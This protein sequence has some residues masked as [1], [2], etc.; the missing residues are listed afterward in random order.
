MRSPKPGRPLT[1]QACA[2]G[3][4]RRKNPKSQ[5][6]ARPSLDGPLPF[7]HALKD[8]SRNV[9]YLPRPGTA[10]YPYIYIYIYISERGA[11]YF[12]PW[13]RWQRG[14]AGE[15]ICLSVCV[16]VCLFPSGS[17]ATR[18]GDPPWRPTLTTHPDDPPWRP[19]LATHPGNPPLATLPPATHP[20]DAS[21]LLSPSGGR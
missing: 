21:S 14:S 20:G 19:T 9:A 2:Q 5:P 16:S 7:W 10:G 8:R 3:I 11:A 4:G 1:V 6:C 15:K 12:D 13:V 17:P 18:P